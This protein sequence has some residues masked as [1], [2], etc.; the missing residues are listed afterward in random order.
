L[1]RTLA[2]HGRTIAIVT[3]NSSLTINRW[4]ERHDASALIQTIVGRDTLL[5]LKPSPAMV[6]ETL[7]RCGVGPHDAIFVGDST[8]DLGAAQA[9]RLTFYGI[10][11]NASRHGHLTAAGASPIFASPAALLSTLGLA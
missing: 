3:S 6:F 10:A 2:G 4:L 9:A 8:A 11:T 1:L 5:A 7:R